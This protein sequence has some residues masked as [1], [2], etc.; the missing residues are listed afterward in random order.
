MKARPIKNVLRHCQRVDK[1]YGDP[2]DPGDQAMWNKNLGWIQALKYVI[3]TYDCTPR[4][5]G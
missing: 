2:I 3:A 1:Q 5:Q 4:E